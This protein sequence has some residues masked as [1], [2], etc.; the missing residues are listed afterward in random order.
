VSE[1][2]APETMVLEIDGTLRPMSERIAERKALYRERPRK[3]REL[4]RRV[5]FTVKTALDHCFCSWPLVVAPTS[6]GHELRCEAHGA[7][8][9]AMARLDELTPCTECGVEGSH[10]ID[11]SRLG[12][13]RPALLRAAARDIASG[14]LWRAPGMVRNL[15]TADELLALAR[16]LE[17]APADAGDLFTSPASSPVPR[18]PAASEP[19][20]HKE[21]SDH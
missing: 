11:C 21:V 16:E 19:D 4:A 5:R 10:L 18:A 15:S 12:A 8:E 2:L 6:T 13:G 1:E 9:R 14:L 17:A 3:E 20:D 7:I